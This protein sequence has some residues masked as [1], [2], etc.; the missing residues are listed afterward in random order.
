MPALRGPVFVFILIIAG[1]LVPGDSRKRGKPPDKPTAIAKREHTAMIYYVDSLYGSDE[2]DGLSRQTAFRTTARVNTLSLCGGDEVRF[3]AGRTYPGPLQPRR[4][5]TEGTVTITRYGVGR[6]PMIDGGGEAAVDLR[7]VSGICLREL[8]V[9]NPCGLYG[10]RILNQAGGEMR[11]I[12]VIGCHIYDVYGGHEAFRIATGG[13]VA[14]SGHEHPGWFR[15]LLIQDNH[16]EHV[17]RTGVILHTYWSNRPWKTWAENDYVS[18]TENWWPSYEVVWRGN[19]IER[20]AGDAMVLIGAIDPLMEWNVAYEVM[21]DP[22]PPCANAGIW[23]QSTENCLVQYNEVGYTHKPE[24][25]NDAQGFDVDLSC[26]NTILQ[27]NYSHDN[28]GGFLLLCE[29]N[30]TAEYGYRGTVVRNNLSVNDG[31]IKGELIAM[32]G[33][34][35]G[36]TIENNTI[37]YAGNAERIIE[38]WTEDGTDQAA[39]VVFRNNLLIANGRG[40]AFH[41]CN[42]KNFVFENNLYWGSYRTPQ[43][44]ETDPVVAEPIL[45]LDGEAGCGPEAAER[46]VPLP[47]SP[48][49]TAGAAAAKPAPADF[50]GNPTE[51][52]Q[53]IGA[54]LSGARK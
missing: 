48:A 20:P 4:A 17:C 24:G 49:L 36:V 51:G 23:P 3:R 39:D 25:C 5:D 44:G 18:D 30:N 2:A 52:R 42:G 10:V 32:V 11:G 27:Y 1:C 12:H 6:R 14:T 22:K 33:P 34:V 21:A 38:V 35:R 43:P 47:G 37:C 50:F 15:D 9:T 16:I 40:N 46:Y 28:E 45:T 53:Y 41:L 54:F 29:L 8:A 19:R 26:R 7:D 13:I 31:N